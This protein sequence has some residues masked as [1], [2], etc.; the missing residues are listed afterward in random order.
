MPKGFHLD[1]VTN[2]CPC[3]VAFDVVNIPGLQLGSCLST[4]N[5]GKLA[6]YTRI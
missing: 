1:G 6:V 5:D 2:C 4:A 3:P